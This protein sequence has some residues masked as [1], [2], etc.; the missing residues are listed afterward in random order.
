MEQIYEK[1]VGGPKEDSFGI[2]V[3][4]KVDRNHHTILNNL[5]ICTR[6][7]EEMELTSGETGEERIIFWGSISV[8][9]QGGAF[10]ENRAQG[11]CTNKVD[12]SCWTTQRS[13]PTHGR[14]I[15]RE[16]T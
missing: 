7:R 11:S 8:P 9:G 6:E 14:P 13:V 15:S 2:K 4:R 16:H 3:G 10:S 12:A 1:T 5:L